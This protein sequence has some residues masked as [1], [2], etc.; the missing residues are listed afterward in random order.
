VEVVI[1]NLY[2]ITGEEFSKGRS[3]AQV[4]EQALKGGAQ[5]IQLREKK[6]ST[7]KLIELG[8][9]LRKLTL[10][11]QATFI[12]NDRVDVALAVDA[13]GVH[14]GQDDMPLADARKL[15]GTKK[16]IG[17]SVDNLV[18]A[19]KAEKTGA[20]YIGVGPIFPT[21]SKDDAAAPLGLDTLKDIAQNITI[22]I[23]AIGGINTTNVSQVIK[24]GADA[25]SVISAIVS[26]ADIEKAA[27]ILANIISQTK[28]ELL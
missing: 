22:P 14:L 17:I 5:V 25:I 19:K 2:V 10:E 20:D 1:S 12:V 9:Q 15:L 23:V 28:E 4:V 6:Y 21:N 16:I 26:A 24:A 11:Y 18:E 8:K 7:A 3:T 27:R 13:D